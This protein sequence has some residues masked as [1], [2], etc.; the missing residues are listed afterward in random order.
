MEGITLNLAKIEFCCKEIRF[1]GHILSTEGIRP[2]PDKVEAIK[3]YPTPRNL[4]HLKDFLRLTQFCSKFTARLAEEIVPL[5]E[6]EKKG[7]KWSWDP[8]HN[9]A[10]L[11]VKELFCAEALLHHPR[12]DHPYH[13][14]SDPR[15]VALG[16]FLHQR[17]DLG[18]ARIV[19]MASRT[20]TGAE[21]NYFRTELELLAIAWALTKFRSFL[22]AEVLIETDHKALCHLLTGRYLNSRLTRWRLAIQ[23]YDLRLNI[24]RV[25]ETTLPT[26]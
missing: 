13:L 24:S 9:E 16:A 19:T 3:N 5:L 21:Y 6:L 23:D 4:K 22:G 8:K 2:D 14:I 1:L 20:Y 18:L 25:R 15:T 10:F 12:R 7:V 11:R 26:H 17:Y